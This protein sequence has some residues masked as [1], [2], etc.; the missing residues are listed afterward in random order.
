[1]LLALTHVR[2]SFAD[3]A[4]NTIQG[5]TMANRT[6]ILV[7]STD[8]ELHRILEI[9]AST[10]RFTFQE[11]GDVK[12]GLGL[13]N[14]GRPDCVIFDLKTLP[15]KRRRDMI[16]KKFEENRTPIMFLN[17]NE[18]GTAQNLS[19]NSSLRIEPLVKFIKSHHDRCCKVANHSLFGRILAFCGFGRN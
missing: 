13:F 1:M 5:E 17:D 18:N 12:T 11:A 10:Y 19:S 3:L 4:G 7:V 14:S 9:I 16:K 2:Q 15:D 6:S 8:S